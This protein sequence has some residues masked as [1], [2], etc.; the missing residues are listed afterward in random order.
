MAS[1]CTARP[2]GFSKDG[3]AKLLYLRQMY[4]NSYKD[5]AQFR[6]LLSKNNPKYKACEF[7]SSFF[8]DQQKNSTYKVNIPIGVIKNKRFA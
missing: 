7:N 4:L 1:I 6:V 2:K 8:D 3:L 5:E